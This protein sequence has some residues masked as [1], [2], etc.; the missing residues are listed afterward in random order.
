[1]WFGGRDWA[2]RQHESVVIDEAGGKVGGLRVE[3][4]PEG[5]A[6]LVAFLRDLAPLEQIACIIETKPGL[7]ITALLEAGLPSIR[8]T[9]KPSI[10]N[11]PP[12]GP[13]PIRVMP[14]SWPSM[15]APGGDARGAW[16]PPPPAGRNIKP[17]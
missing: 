10:G 11:V 16:T 15:A 5:L 3:D 4:T 13:R 1:M 14:P 17:L 9:R 7:L 8:P 2:Y 12:R 6:K